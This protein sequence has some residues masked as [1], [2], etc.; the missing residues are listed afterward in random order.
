VF[1]T[2][3][4]ERLGLSIGVTTD[5]ATQ[6]AGNA[7]KPRTERTLAAIALLCKGTVRDKKYVLC[8]FFRHA[9][10]TGG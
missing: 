8:D 7:K 4:P 5:F 6:I 9:V 2:S 10:R 1:Q 3:Q